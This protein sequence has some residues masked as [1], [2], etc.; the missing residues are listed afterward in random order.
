VAL[1]GKITRSG[2]G[3]NLRVRL[4]HTD[5]VLEWF[6]PENSGFNPLYDNPAPVEYDFMV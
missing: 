4:L 6:E 5:H 3:S 2:A 1:D